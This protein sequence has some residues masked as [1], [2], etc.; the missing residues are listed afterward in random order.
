MTRPCRNS[1]LS[2]CFLCLLWLQG[3]VWAA[4]PEVLESPQAAARALPFSDGVRVAGMIYLSG[5]IGTDPDSNELVK[6][7]IRAETQQALSI[8]EGLLERY[9]SSMD[10]VVKCTVMLAD[11]ADYAAMNEVYVRFF[12]GPKPARS[13]FAA[14]ALAKGART[15][16]EC[17]ALA[18]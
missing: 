1:I 13:T 7:G 12:P 11:I 8:I 16:I 2:M 4:Q 10:R 15:E 6:G 3:A 14:A 5:V 18:E 17:W 9:G